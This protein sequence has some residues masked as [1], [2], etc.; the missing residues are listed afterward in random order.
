MAKSAK[1][2]KST[3]SA[4]LDLLES[5]DRLTRKIN[6]LIDLF[7][8][9]NL[10]MEQQD[11]D[12]ELISKLNNIVEQNEKIAE[13][14][15]AVADMAKDIKELIE[16]EKKDEDEM[17]DKIIHNQAIEEKPPYHNYPNYQSQYP[18]PPESIPAPQ[19]QPFPATDSQTGFQQ[20]NSVPEFPKPERP[21]INPFESNLFNKPE[22]TRQTMQNVQTGTANSLF[23]EPSLPPKISDDAL[24]INPI[25]QN[26]APKPLSFDEN[27]EKNDKN[28]FS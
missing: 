11:I 23:K 19:P 12:T 15:L 26:T 27:K 24:G 2:A 22:N 25:Q 8:A 28:I 9:A 4:E 21:G 5:I 13:G 3:R 10:Q 1:K 18:Y 7:S 6:E 14:I 16:K 17:F 20:Q